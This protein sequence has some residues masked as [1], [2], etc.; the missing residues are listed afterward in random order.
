MERM[1]R[2]TGQ[3]A[4]MFSKMFEAE[5]P[6]LQREGLLPP[7]TIIL[8]MLRWSARSNTGAIRKFLKPSARGRTLYIDYVQNKKFNACVATEGDLDFVAVFEGTLTASLGLFCHLLAQP[9]FLPDV[10][11][12]GVEVASP[13]VTPATITPIPIRPFVSPPIPNIDD[14]FPK[15]KA[16]FGLAIRLAEMSM[17]FLCAHET[18]HLLGGHLEVLNAPKKFF[19]VPDHPTTDTLRTFELDADAFAAFSSGITKCN[20]CVAWMSRLGGLFDSRV[21]RRLSAHYAWGFAISTLFRY[22]GDTLGAMGH[23]D[24]YPPAEERAAFAVVR[25]YEA[26]GMPRSEA[27][28]LT[29]QVLADA[30]KEWARAHAPIKLQLPEFSGNSVWSAVERMEHELKRAS[31]LFGD[32]QRTEPVWRRA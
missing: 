8:R 23:S 25:G 30:S 12:S 24:R 21:A 1:S 2:P 28:G 10:G 4:A 16:R 3:A 9:T 14:L 15:D 26:V 6:T 17:D 31:T 5:G 11:N 19:M 29:L 20:R 18:G 13:G 27:R 22:L 7:F 32:S